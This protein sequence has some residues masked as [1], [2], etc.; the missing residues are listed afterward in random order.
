[1]WIFCVYVK[2]KLKL[3]P[4]S[5][6]K[7]LW[8]V[9]FY[10]ILYICIFPYRK[11]VRHFLMI[12]E[13]YEYSNILVLGVY[14]WFSLL[15][16]NKRHGMYLCICVIYNFQLSHRSGVW[17]LSSDWYCYSV[18]YKWSEQQSW[19]SHIWGRLQVTCHLQ[20]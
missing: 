12:S 7:K 3:D 11:D 18:L 8:K 15:L 2:W 20:H 13:E 17:L 1:M 19:W 14:L 4:F 16:N 10:P 6:W 5:F 9:L